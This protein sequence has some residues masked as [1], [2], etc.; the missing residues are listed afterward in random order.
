MSAP[1][2]P[3]GAY[4]ATGVGHRDGIPPRAIGKFISPPIGMAPLHASFRGGAERGPREP[5]TC[6]AA[7]LLPKGKS[8]LLATK[9]CILQNMLLEI[10]LAGCMVCSIQNLSF[11]RPPPPAQPPRRLRRL[12]FFR[13]PHPSSAGKAAA[14]FEGVFFLPARCRRQSRC[15]VPGNIVY[16]CRLLLASFARLAGEMGRGKGAARARKLPCRGPPGHTV[17][18]SVKCKKRTDLK[19][20]RQAVM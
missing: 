15:E 20:E 6:H 8:S 16:C 17:S 2:R 12:S 18:I 11:C 9:P 10:V 4:S 14:Q 5:E 19:G 7:T 3:W 13:P 1:A